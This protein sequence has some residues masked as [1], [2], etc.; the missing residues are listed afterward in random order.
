MPLIVNEIF[1]SIQGESTWAGLPFVFVRLTGCNLRCRYCD[2]TYAYS[3]GNPLEIAE[4]LE[5]VR[6]FGCRRVTITGGEPMLQEPTP[7]LIERLI[8]AGYTVTLE[9]N[10]SLDIE[11]VDRHCIRIMD[12]K[13]PSSGM[14]QH[15]RMENLR[16][17]GPDDQVKIVIADREDFDFAASAICH[18]GNLLPPWNL[19]LSPVHGLAP[20]Q[21]ARWILDAG[22]N[23]RLQIQLHRYI[24]PDKDR[25]V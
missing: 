12:L 5:R 7:A 2:T 1:H 8:A 19:L 9:T 24:W 10:G 13:A 22:I 23:A 3:E 11:R 21:L 14:Q 25:G 17:L 16:S 6:R 4:V 15:N 20:A 18:I